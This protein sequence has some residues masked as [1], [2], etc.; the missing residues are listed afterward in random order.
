VVLVGQ[1][2]ALAIA[3]R[4][5]R[6]AAAGRSF[7]TGWRT[8][9]G[10]EMVCRSAG[11]PPLCD[12]LAPP[13]DA[14]QRARYTERSGSPS[15]AAY[16]RARRPGSHRGPEPVQSQPVNRVRAGRQQR[17]ADPVMCRRDLRAAVGPRAPFPW[18]N[19]SS[20]SRAQVPAAALR[21]V[22]GQQAVTQTLQNAIKPDGSRRPIS[23][24]APAASAR[25]RP[26]AS[27]R[28]R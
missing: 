24:P 21:A 25:R 12:R 7:G 10:G 19:S 4:E 9:V 28:P 5:R 26:R 2:K 20:R 17:S 8:V 23:S 11:V 3:V 6:S 27:S 22:V 14:R 16:G 13:V 18:N 15:G 1:P